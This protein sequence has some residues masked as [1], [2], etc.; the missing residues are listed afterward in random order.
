MPNITKPNA[1]KPKF[2]GNNKVSG[3]N[4]K[5]L[6]E[7]NTAPSIIQILLSILYG[8]FAINGIEKLYVIVG[9]VKTN[10]TPNGPNPYVCKC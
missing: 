7:L 3:P 10:P 6:I 2:L 9:I 8:N 1:T 4:K 5:K